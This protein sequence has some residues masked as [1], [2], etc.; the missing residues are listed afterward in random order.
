MGER[1]DAEPARDLLVLARLGL[2]PFLGPDLAHAEIM[3]ARPDAQRR[4][5]TGRLY[6]RRRGMMSSLGRRFR[7]RRRLW[8]R[9]GWRKVAGRPLHDLR[10]KVS[11]DESISRWMEERLQIDDD[12]W[13][14]VLG[15]NN[16]GT[17][18]IQRILTSTRARGCRTRDRP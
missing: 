9:Y 13:L 3:A 11:S 16:S 14:F 7:R 10:W 5:V 15:L 6:T 8:R 4:P 18:I 17:S 1:A 12:Y 2:E